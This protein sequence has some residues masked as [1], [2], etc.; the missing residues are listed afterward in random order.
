M[1]CHWAFQNHNFLFLLLLGRP[2]G[3]VGVL[4]VKTQCCSIISRY[5]LITFNLSGWACNASCKEAP[6]KFA[7][8]KLH[9][10]ISAKKK[11]CELQTLFRFFRNFLVKGD[12][13][14]FDTMQLCR[15]VGLKIRR[16][17]E[18]QKSLGL[19]IYH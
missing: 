19:F 3:Y 7:D 12:F 9:Q 8:T 1:W 10:K 13:N 15:D 17:D 16:L 5:Y 18:L 2:P 6:P 4:F 14:F 11:V